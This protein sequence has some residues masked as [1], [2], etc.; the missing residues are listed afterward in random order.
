MPLPDHL[1]ENIITAVISGGGTAV[2]AIYAFFK[3]V[4]KRLDDLEKKIGS[5]ESGSGLSFKV[6]NLEASYA[7]LKSEVTNWANHPPA[8][9]LQVFRSQRISTHDEFTIDD[10]IRSFESRLKVM[11]ETVEK[12]ERR[13]KSC[14]SEDDFEDADRERAE[15]IASVRTTIAEVSG[16]LKGL[17]S[18][19]GLV[20]RLD[21]YAH[22]SRGDLL[23]P[24]HFPL[25][26]SNDSQGR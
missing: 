22:P 19:L 2:S 3:D 11:E 4:K 23:W 12:L 9:L 20:R 26:S 21:P 8:S 14:V 15:E 1:I 5:V 16:L 17:Q 7:S 10:R 13:V 25:S 24:T 18:A 6:Q